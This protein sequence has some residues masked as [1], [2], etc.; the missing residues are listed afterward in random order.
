MVIELRT[1]ISGT[2]RDV[3]RGTGVIRSSDAGH[4]K[5]AEVRL[6]AAQEVFNTTVLETIES[7]VKR[8]NSIGDVPE[9]VTHRF[10]GSRVRGLSLY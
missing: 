4:G 6:D 8:Q 9:G 3:Y 7:V 2:L 10:S 5:E 1:E